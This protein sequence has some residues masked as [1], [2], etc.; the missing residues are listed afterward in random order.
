MNGL[1]RFR[2]LTAVFSLV[3]GV[4]GGHGA[5]PQ[6]SPDAS[7]NT[8]PTSRPSPE[9]AAQD[10]AAR[11]VALNKART[12]WL[13]GRRKRILLKAEVVLR[14]GLLEMLCCLK[15]TKEHESILAVDAKAYVI[16]TGLLAVGAKP[17][18]PVRFS[19]EFR[20]ATGQRIDIFLQWTDAAG[21]AHRVAAQ[22]WVRHALHR[23]FA[24]SLTQLPQGFTLPKDSDLR[25]D[26]RNS[27]LT[28][29]GR[30][31]GK[32]REGLLAL[33]QDAAFHKAVQSLYQQSQPRQMQTAWLFAGSGLF[34][35]EKT[36]KKYYQAEGGDVICVANFP[37]AMLDLEVESSA[38]GQEHLVFEAA[39]ERIP[40]LGTEVTIELVPV[41]EKCPPE[42]QAG[43]DCR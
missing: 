14:E 16:H 39:T 6:T 15:R 34:T 26:K 41:F 40:P 21:R 27:E 9:N 42:S 36:A 19:P 22:H 2:A 35:D 3:V 11:M 17:G 7:K 30:M 43:K 13:D 33:S 38:S 1:T 28:W 24:A 20:P 37:S 12:V 31:T 8:A 5:E 32:Q 23:Y 18:T 10:S 25:H 4:C 29:Y